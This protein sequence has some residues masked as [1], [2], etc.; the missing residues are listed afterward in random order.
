MR[1]KILVGLL[2]LIPKPVV[3]VNDYLMGEHTVAPLAPFGGGHY[4]TL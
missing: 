2:E 3:V 4:F 1:G